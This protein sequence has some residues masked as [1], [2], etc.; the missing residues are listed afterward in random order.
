MRSVS[1]AILAVSGVLVATAVALGVVR[2]RRAKASRVSLV[3]DP[4]QAFVGAAG[5]F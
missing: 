1:I 2:A 4:L 3:V 5:R